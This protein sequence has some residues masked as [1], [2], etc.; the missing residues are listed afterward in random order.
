MTDLCATCGASIIYVISEAGADTWGS[1][2]EW[3]HVDSLIDLA[4]YPKASGTPSDIADIH[5]AAEWLNALAADAEEKSRW[6]TTGPE[7][8]R[9]LAALLDA[10]RGYTPVRAVAAESARKILE[11]VADD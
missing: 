4:H 11:W 10:A 1:Q 9:A 7:V 8:I 6:T 2:S 3:Q 5:R